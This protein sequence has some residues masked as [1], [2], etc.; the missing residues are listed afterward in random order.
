MTRC[1]RELLVLPILGLYGR[2]YAEYKMIISR[3][4]GSVASVAAKNMASL[5]SG[6]RRMSSMRK[7][8]RGSVVEKHL[9]HLVDAE[10]GSKRRRGGVHVGLSRRASSF[11]GRSGSCDAGG[12]Q[13]RRDSAGSALGGTQCTKLHSKMSSEELDTLTLENL[14]KRPEFAALGRG[15]HSCAVHSPAAFECAR[16]PV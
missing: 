16:T 7:S 2:L 14:A 10:Q 5:R 15:S 6:Q 9:S 4:H 3:R 1:D 11:A 8:V 12:R 13:S